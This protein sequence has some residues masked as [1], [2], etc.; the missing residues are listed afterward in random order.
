MGLGVRLP[1]GAHHTLCFGVSAHVLG[2]IMKW[3]VYIL[4]CADGSLYTGITI[5]LKRRELQHNQGTGAKSVLGKRPVKIIY[6]SVYNNR[7]EA[8]KREHEI[9]GWRKEKKL[10]L[11]QKTVY[12]EKHS[13]E[14]SGSSMVEQRTLNP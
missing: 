9:K 6:S 1:S 3:F 2:D 8:L 12:P 7:S 13:D 11:I 10:S 4:E 14:G 5:D